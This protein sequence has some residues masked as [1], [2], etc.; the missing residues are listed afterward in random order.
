VTRPSTNPSVVS[1]REV[2]RDNL[3]TI[4]ELTVSAVQS[5]YVATNAKSLAQAFF[6]QDITWFRAIYWGNTA[7]G[8]VML[9][10]EPGKPPY[11]W[12]LMVDVS[13]QG[14]GIGQRTLDLV[15]EKLSGEG[16]A[17]LRTSYFPGPDSPQGFYEKLG[18]VPTGEIDDDEVVMELSLSA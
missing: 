3:D 1:L 14:K 9:E 6:Y 16:A 4:L 7:A 18:F 10:Q 13:F 15:V 17:L 2:T 8:F 11:L 5:E 12:R